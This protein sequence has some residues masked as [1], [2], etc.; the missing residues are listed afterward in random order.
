[1]V[2]VGASVSKT[3]CAGM[4]NTAIA[5][6]RGIAVLLT[7][8]NIDRSPS[9]EN[10]LRGDDRADCSSGRAQGQG[11]HSQINR[12]DFHNNADAAT[13]SGGS[14]LDKTVMRRLRYRPGRFKIL[15]SKNLSIPRHSPGIRLV[16]PVR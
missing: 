14:W 10:P 2:F 5:M 6:P 16:D 13:E 1:M 11:L 9:V 15:F 3:A 4:T 8:T 7:C 12:I